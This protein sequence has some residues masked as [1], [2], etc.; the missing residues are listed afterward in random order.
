MATAALPANLVYLRPSAGRTTDG[1]EVRVS[2]EPRATVVSRNELLERLETVGSLAPSAPL[3][4][5]IVQVLGLPALAARRAAP[6]RE[7]LFRALTNR[8]RGLT[9]AT[10]QI[11]RFTGSTVGIVLQGTGAAAAA[12]VASRITHHLNMLVSS[13]SPALGV[14]V[15]AAT[16]TG[17]NAEF[18]PVAALDSFSEDC[19]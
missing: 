2:R 15:Y 6:G 16:G 7:D 12:A 3:S 17:V 9:R 8:L 19:C 14:T 13:Y 11:G 1:S 5:L 10:D 4:F 18:L